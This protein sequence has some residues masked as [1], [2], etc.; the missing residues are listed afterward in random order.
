MSSRVQ[1]ALRLAIT[2][3][4]AITLCGAAHASVDLTYKRHG[5]SFADSERVNGLRFNFVDR[6]IREV[7]GVNVTLWRGDEPPNSKV[8]GLSLGLFPRAT[9]LTGVQVGLA[10]VWAW[11]RAWGRRWT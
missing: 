1:A 10:S 4:V 5:L 9:E 2:A 8:R 11:R 7:N 3:T 6:R